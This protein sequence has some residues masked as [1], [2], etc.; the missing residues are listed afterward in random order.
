MS[1]IKILDSEVSD[2]S[3]LN[4]DEFSV[5]VTPAVNDP[6]YFRFEVGTKVRVIGDGE[7]YT[8]SGRTTSAGTSF[9]V[10]DEAQAYYCGSTVTKF[11]VSGRYSILSFKIL[12][13]E[14][15][16]YVVNYNFEFDTRL[17]YLRTVYASRLDIKALSNKSALGIVSLGGTGVTGEI[18][19]MVNSYN[20]QEITLYRTAV[21]GT[22]SDIGG[23]FTK[24]TALSVVGSPITGTAADLKA[25]ARAAGRTTG[26][27]SVID[28]SNQSTTVDFSTP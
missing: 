3:L 8:N 13:G 17:Y 27:C 28:A 14:A 23:R 9:T 5:D 6:I 20:T 11:A 2:N 15:R 7:F 1:M 19:N 22:M 18:A 21:S 26:T 16:N 25:A 4:I 10:A 24:L 12:N